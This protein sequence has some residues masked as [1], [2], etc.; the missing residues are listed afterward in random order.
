MSKKYEF[1][2]MTSDVM[3]QAYGRDLGEM[4]ENAAEAMFSVICEIDKIEPRLEIK[5]DVEATNLEDLLFE[6]LSRLL[7]E[8]E[9]QELFLSRFEISEIEKNDEYRVRGRAFGEKIS[10]DKGSTLVKGVTYYELDVKETPKGFVGKVSLD[11]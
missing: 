2:D 8:A 7:T 5:V 1:L 6:W 10:E 11:I 4:L 9:I 3:Y